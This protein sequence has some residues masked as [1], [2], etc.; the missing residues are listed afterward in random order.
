MKLFFIEMLI[1]IMN[2]LYRDTILVLIF[3]GIAIWKVTVATMCWIFIAHTYS[4]LW[5]QLC[6]RNVVLLELIHTFVKWLLNGYK[7]SVLLQFRINSTLI[8]RHGNVASIDYTALS[9]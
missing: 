6:C 7:L 3:F 5:K 4:K 2:S 9:I 1:V 8:W